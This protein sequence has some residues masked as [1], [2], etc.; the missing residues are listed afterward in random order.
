MA[1]KQVKQQKDEAIS[2][3]EDETQKVVDEETKSASA[4]VALG[5]EW[6]KQMFVEWYDALRQQVSNH[7]YRSWLTA[8]GFG[9]TVGRARGKA[10]KSVIWSLV[11]KKILAPLGKKAIAT[12][13]DQMLSQNKKESP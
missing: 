4:D 2:S 12:L 1:K 13:L 5:G 7:P 6:I 8:L 10:W 3:K 11:G 9:Y